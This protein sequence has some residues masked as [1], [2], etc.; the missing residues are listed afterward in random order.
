MLQL[1]FDYKLIIALLIPFVG[2]TLGSAMVYL[3]KN[4]IYPKVLKLL[5]GF[6]SGIMIASAIWSLLLPAIETYSSNDYKRWLVPSIGFIV[7]ILFLLLL[8]IL[9]PH[10]HTNKLEEGIK[11]N[12]LSSTTKLL[13]AITIHNIPEGLA[14]GLVIASAMNGGT[15]SQSALILSL[16]IAIQNFLEGAIVSMPLKETGISKTKAFILGTLSGIVEPIAALIA[17]LLC[18]NI[19]IVLPYALSFAAGAMI[20]VVADEL[21]PQASVSNKSCLSTI[22]LAIG[23]IL[24][25]VLDIVLG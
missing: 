12:K 24:M 15:L 19:T 3:L 5:L 20:Y 13:L 1:V 14:V 17:I 21:I 9:V 16:G 25:M 6:A 18:A 4:E 2:T 8:D 22:G 23:F 10:M 11:D 7:G